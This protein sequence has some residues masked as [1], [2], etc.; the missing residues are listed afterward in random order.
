MILVKPSDTLLHVFMKICPDRIKNSHIFK[1]L[2]GFEIDV[3]C[4][5]RD[6]DK[7]SMRSPSMNAG[8]N[9]WKFLC[10]C[11]FSEIFCIDSHIE[12]QIE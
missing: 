3:M 11:R 12:E 6:T 8:D 9:H 1:H 10:I 7:I 5:L 4:L 2:K